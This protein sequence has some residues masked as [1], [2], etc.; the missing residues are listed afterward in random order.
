MSRKPGDDAMRKSRSLPMKNSEN[1]GQNRRKSPCWRQHEK[2]LGIAI[3][4]VFCLNGPVIE[5]AII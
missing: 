4:C 3:V 2:D 5:F 1:L